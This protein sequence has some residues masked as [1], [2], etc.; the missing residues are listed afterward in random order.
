M[1][2]YIVI[3]EDRHFDIRAVPFF[4]EDKAVAFARKTAKDLC[5]H[6]DCYE[7]DLELENWPFYAK[8][9]AEGDSVHVI[10]EEV[11]V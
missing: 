10:V 6:E 8:Y 9:S 7:E 1:R 11:R 2:V 4:S 3:T 5:R